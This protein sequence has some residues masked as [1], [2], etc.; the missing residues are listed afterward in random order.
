[1]PHCAYSSDG[2][3]VDRVLERVGLNDAGERR[4]KGYS[5]G[6]RQRLAL[7][8]ALMKQPDL[9]VLDEPTNRRTAS[10]HRASDSCAP[11]SPKRQLGVSAFS[12]PATCSMRSLGSATNW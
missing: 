3:R 10:T 8:T 9:L 5:Q 12:S 6:M 7:A 1:M 4:V 2:G 11:S